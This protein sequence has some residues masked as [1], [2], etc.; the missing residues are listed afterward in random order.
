MPTFVTLKIA[1]LPQSLYIL[2][3]DH[4]PVLVNKQI[5]LIRLGTKRGKQVIH[6]AKLKDSTHLQFTVSHHNTHTNFIFMT[7]GRKLSLL[8]YFNKNTRICLIT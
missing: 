5:H 7:E 2:G 3:H 8:E 4:V 1:R 6:F